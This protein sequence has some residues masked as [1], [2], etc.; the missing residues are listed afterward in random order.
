[1]AGIAAT[2]AVLAVCSLT[3]CKGRTMENMA[4]N[5]ETIEVAPDTIAADL[6]V[7]ADT[8]ATL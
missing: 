6:P 7:T 3:G 8:V 5:G 4:P 2:A 1:M